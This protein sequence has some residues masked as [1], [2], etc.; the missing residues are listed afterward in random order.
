LGHDGKGAG[1][2]QRFFVESAMSRTRQ[3]EKV[4]GREWRKR[5]GIICIADWSSKIMFLW[6]Y[7][8]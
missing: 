1:S 2:G 6:E 5:Q 7:L 4:S 3:A 8:Y